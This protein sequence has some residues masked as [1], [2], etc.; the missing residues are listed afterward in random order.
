MS[1]VLTPEPILSTEYDVPIINNIKDTNIKYSSSDN[2]YFLFSQSLENSWNYSNDVIKI[3]QI[4]FDDKESFNISE[5]QI[6]LISLANDL[7]KDNKLLEGRSR[8]I[9]NKTF[10]RTVKRKPTLLG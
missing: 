6:D 1:P 9:L 3:S 8:E 7:F 2:E 4:E 10:L 5:K